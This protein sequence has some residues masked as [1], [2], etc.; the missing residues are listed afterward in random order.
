MVNHK[1]KIRN[2]KI[3]VT[4]GAGFVGH[5]L[6]KTLVNDFNC[7]VIVVDDLSNSSEKTL[8]EVANKIEFHKISVCDGK[9]LF[10]L[11]K[12]VNYIFHLA[13]KQISS[14]GLEPNIHL[15]V[16]A[17]STL[18]ILEYIRHNK[19]PDLKRFIY[20]GSTSIYG[21]SV[22]LPVNENDRPDVLSNY[23]ATKLLGEN[24]TSMYCRNY[25]IPVSVVRYSNVYGYGQSPRNPYAGVL[26]K[27][28]H[29]ALIGETLKIFG[30]GE[31]TRDYTFISDAVDAT[32]LAAVHPRAYGDVFNIGT[33]V[34][35]SVKKLVKIIAEI[36]DTV[37]YEHVPERDIDNI[38]RRSIDIS[39]IHKNLGWA[40]RFGIERGIKETIEWYRTTL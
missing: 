25:D 38:R 22:K 7:N 17:E 28:I 14:S 39:K 15:R 1:K 31:Q 3:L 19:L 9:K 4:G 12:D 11:F 24:Y 6:V 13:C 18:N 20:T 27:F 29:N 16:N 40:P 35:T 5:N 37:K 26:G 21:S 23:A 34:E 10:P 2:Q 32:I 30:D 33:T 36:I 8:S